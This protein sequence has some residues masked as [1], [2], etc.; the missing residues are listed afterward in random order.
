MTDYTVSRKI[1]QD[2]CPNKNLSG[3]KKVGAGLLP[4]PT[5]HCRNRARFENGLS[6]QIVQFRHVIVENPVF[7]FLGEIGGVLG[8]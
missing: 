7:L 6:G 4:A 2:F 1:G 8:E 5:S 3:P